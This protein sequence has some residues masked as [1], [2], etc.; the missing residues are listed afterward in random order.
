[1]NS[2]RPNFSQGNRQ[3]PGGGTPSRSTGL[4]DREYGESFRPVPDAVSPKRAPAAQHA[5]PQ[6]A[7]LGTA[8]EIS[9]H[10]NLDHRVEMCGLMP[11][12]DRDAEIVKRPNGRH[13]F[14][15]LMRCGSVWVCP[16]CRARIANERGDEINEGIQAVHAL[17]AHASIVTLTTQ[18]SVNDSL[19]ELL[20]ALQVA[21]RL[22]FS[23]RGWTSLAERMGYL[24]RI[25]AIEVKY[26]ESTGW[27]PHVH[28]LVFHS[29]DIDADALFDR[30]RHALSLQERVAN[31]GAFD[32]RRVSADPK[33]AA[34]TA[35]YIAKMETLSYQD[36]STW[37]IG[38]EMTASHAKHS[39]GETP[40]Q[41]LDRAANGDADAIEAYGEYIEATKG[42]RSLVWSRNLRKK[43]GLGDAR[44]DEEIAND[45]ENEGETVRTLS[46]SENFAL[47]EANLRAKLLREADAHGLPGIERVIVEAMSRVYG[48]RRSPIA[49]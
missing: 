47:V 6:Y 24:G 16:A 26:N 19:A 38:D 35:A 5:Y 27:H 25:R 7:R 17:D 44:S 15:N 33:S 28:V 9:K 21:L 32:V 43:L 36:E 30:W 10:L 4:L 45:N 49:A 46:I 20:D 22:T 42:I 40:E 8:R 31:R 12:P 13:G 29:G 1:M 41:L 11:L 14:S 23:G 48:R 3:P 2:L 34:R 39:G 37:S 18:H